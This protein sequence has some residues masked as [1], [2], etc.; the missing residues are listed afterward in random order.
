MQ[1]VMGGIGILNSTAIVLHIQST[2][3]ATYQCRLNDGPNL[4]C[5]VDLHLI[6]EE[7][8]IILQVVISK[9]LQICQEETMH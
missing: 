5:E 7:I 9:L 6:F 3:P 1:M 2:L 4:T 8:W